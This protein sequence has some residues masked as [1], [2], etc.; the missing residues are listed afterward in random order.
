MTG[1]TDHVVVVGA[2]FSG[3]SAAL[4]LLGAGRRVTLVER[5]DHP[6]GRA[7]A[8]DLETAAGTYRVDPGPTVLTMPSLLEEAFGAVGEKLEER[9]DLVPLDP[10]YRARFADGSTIDVHTDVDAMEA[11]IRRVCGPDAAAGYGRLRTL[12][13]AAL[14]RRDRPVHRRELRLAA[15]AARTGPGPAGRARRV[16]PARPADRP[17]PARRAVAADLLLPGPLRGRA[18]A[19]GA[20]RVRRDRL[21]G[22]D[23]RGVLPPRRDA[24]G[25]PGARRRG[26]RRRRGDRLRAHGDGAGAVGRARHRGPPPGRRGRPDGAPGLRRG[27]AHPGPAGGA[28][29]ARPGAAPSRAAA[30]VAERGRPARRGHPRSSRAGPPHDLVRRGVGVDVPGDHRR[31]PADE[32]P[33]AAGH[34]AHGD[35]SGARPRRPGPA[36][37]ARPVPEHGGAA[38]S[39][40]RASGPPTATSCCACWRP[41]AS[42]WT[43]SLPRSRCRGWSRPRTGRPTGS[44]R[45]R[46][47]RSPTR[48]R[49]PGR[50]GRATSCAGLDNVVLA[51]CGTTPGVGIPPVLISGRLAAERITG[52]RPAAEGPYSRLTTLV[53]ALATT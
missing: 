2:G 26:G 42:G 24:P 33:V 19:A 9:L 32:R 25:R 50:S 49:R 18:A 11:E 7:G 30:V 29:A 37:R 16:R 17:V 20:R 52:G 31:G 36:V 12:A 8:L 23:R 14:P 43:G 38:R 41:A 5:A 28:P 10:A 35:R 13:D 39:T 22:H 53:R 47:S 3:L 27:G 51:G 46:R 21:H 45:A 44:G 15:G 1:P 6:G 40:G 4:H 48:S 34:P